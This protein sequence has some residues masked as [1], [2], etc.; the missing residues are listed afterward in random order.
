[1]NSSRVGYFLFRDTDFKYF[2]QKISNN[3]KDLIYC[4]INSSI[5]DPMFNYGLKILMKDIENKKI[6]TL[7]FFDFYPLVVSDFLALCQ[8]NNVKTIYVQH[9]YMDLATTSTL[10]SK[11]KN[12]T[13]N[14]KLYCSLLVNFGVNFTR[15]SKIV[16][17]FI[18]GGY[19]GFAKSGNKVFF[20]EC[21]FWDEVSLNKFNK[22]ENTSSKL[23]HVVGGIDSFVENVESSDDGCILYV[24]Q[25]LSETQ[26]MSESRFFQ[27]IDTV[28]QDEYLS[29]SKQQDSE[30]VVLLHPKLVKF[31]QRI[32][33]KYKVQYSSEV[34]KLGVK[35]IIGHF[36]SLLQYD[37]G[38]VPVT[39]RDYGFSEIENQVNDA[40]NDRQRSLVQN[41]SEFYRISQR[42]IYNE[43]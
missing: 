8:K 43:K 21:L 20:D 10:S 22:F 13:H 37:Y 38:A 28:Y 31:E 27:L 35:R 3:D 23:N 4:V 25:P 19:K 14:A 40:K 34:T 41:N 9:G 5:H 18:Y 24:T 26:H 39:M 33:S 15:L 16:T 29:E 1:M 30:F 6:D 2:A 32:S 12:F 17:N 36:S 42:I 7:V 11:M